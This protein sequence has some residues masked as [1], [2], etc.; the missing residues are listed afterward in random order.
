MENLKRNIEKRNGTNRVRREGFTLIELLVVIAIIAI[1]AG[2]LLPALSRA[3][4]MGRRISCVNNLRQLGL[5]LRLYSDDNDGHFTPRVSVGRW[6]AALQASY[7]NTNILRCPTDGFNPAPLSL[8]TSDSAANQALYPGDSAPR[9]YMINGWNDYFQQN[10]A[11]DFNT[12]M[13]GNSPLSMKENDVLY[14][15]QTVAFGEKRTDSGQ[16]YMDLDEGNVGND[17]TE[18]ELGRHSSGSGGTVHTG[19]TG[20][21]TS[22][23]GS[24]GSNHAFVDG[25]A[26]FVKYGMALG[27]VNEWAVT[28][29]GRITYAQVF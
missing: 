21:S 14:P 12:Y 24:G 28:D 3:K 19:I 15:S 26:T 7:G 29:W 16:F 1:L 17:L 25:S 22:G 10:D 5:S 18:L 8:G 13:A 20:T 4:E 9:S 23:Y 6:P 27:P 2:M 11:N